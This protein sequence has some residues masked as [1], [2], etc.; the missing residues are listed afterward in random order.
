MY[1][2][3]ETSEWWRGGLTSINASPNSLLRADIGANALPKLGMP[4]VT[5]HVNVTWLYSRRNVNIPQYIHA[6][7]TPLHIA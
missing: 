5:T 7:H 6:N 1:I 2:V 3:H 4:P